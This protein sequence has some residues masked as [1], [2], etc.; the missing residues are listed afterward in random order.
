VSTV[1]DRIRGALRADAETVTPESIRQLHDP[2][3]HPAGPRRPRSRWARRLIPV[4]AAAAV[5]AVAVAVAVGPGTS[6]GYQGIPR[7]MS[8]S[9]RSALAGNGTASHPPFLVGVGDGS[10]VAGLPGRD[11]GVYS[12]AT[13]QLLA[14]LA[15]PRKGYSFAATAATA[16]S[17]TFIVAARVEDGA[18]N[19]YLYRLRLGGRGQVAGLTP[20]TVPEVA[21]SVWYLTASADG[22]VIAFTTVPCRDNGTSSKV[23]VIDMATGK[24]RTWPSAPGTANE[25]TSISMAANGRWLAFID[26]QS[27]PPTVRVMSTDAA[28]GPIQQRS[29]A[30]LSQT[31]GVTESGGIALSSSG[32][33]LLA[34]FQPPNSNL[35]RIVVFGAAS[36]DP[37]GEFQV[38]YRSETAPCGVSLDPAGRW[39]LVTGIF[40]LLH[41]KPGLRFKHGR[42]YLGARVDLATGRAT[43][44]GTWSGD[45]PPLNVSW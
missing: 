17:R 37:L 4:A 6:R 2:R 21:G 8:P 18:C 9:A 31:A 23:G 33:E 35:Y 45:V 34:C 1:E 16:D 15:P 24:V 5:A 36:G 42:R 20:L 27:R 11:L 38:R 12:A 39:L 30:V 41:G 14:H 13:G 25:I 28:P 44:F 3:P 40:P 10:G 26:F 22:N 43:L 19:S 29:R 32:T 7:A